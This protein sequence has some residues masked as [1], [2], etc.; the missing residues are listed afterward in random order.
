MRQ[1]SSE[2]H[3]PHFPA[4]SHAHSCQPALFSCCLIS[5]QLP[6]LVIGSIMRQSSVT[7]CGFKEQLHYSCCHA[8][9]WSCCICFSFAFLLIFPV[10]PVTV[11]LKVIN[12][13]GTAIVWWT[14]VITAHGLGLDQAFWIVP[15]I[16]NS[17]DHVCEPNKHRAL[18]RFLTWAGI[19]LQVFAN[20]C[21]S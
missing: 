14:V 7:Q 21:H 4:V 20:I 8:L 6:V 2:W 10:L 5:R 15:K 13:T 9:H 16:L 1:E 11:A 12:A 18:F 19:K 17:N 3:S